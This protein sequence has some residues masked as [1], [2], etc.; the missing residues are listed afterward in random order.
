MRVERAVTLYVDMR[1]TCGYPT[2]DARILNRFCRFVGPNRSLHVIRPDEVRRFIDTGRPVTGGWDNKYYMLRKFYRFAIARRWASKDPTPAVRPKRDLLFTPYIY[3]HDEL[4]LLFEA[5]NA[6]DVKWKTLH[7]QTFRTLAILVYGA[8]L[9]LGEAMRLTHADVDF[10]TNLLTIRRSK[11]EKTRI[12]PI[13]SDLAQ[14]L[15]AYIHSNA[16]PYSAAPASLVFACQNGKPIR[17]RGIRKAFVRFRNKA[18]IRRTD[19]SHFQPR[20][21]DLRATFAVHRLTSWYQQGKDVR[22]LLPLLSCYLGHVS[23]QA[24]QIY[25]TMTPELLAQASH[26]FQRFAEQP[27]TAHA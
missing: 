10:S 6:P 13:G 20:L 9:R 12:L 5:R 15:R 14:M 26:R 21:H 19:G 2:F 17:D 25:S 3:T 18:G 4:Q 7:P 11:F 23:I 24:T 1:K 27:E 16:H 8:G 22:K